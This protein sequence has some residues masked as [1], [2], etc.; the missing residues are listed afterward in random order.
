M[1]DKLSNTLAAL[2]DPTRRAILVRLALGDASVSD[3]AAP[4]DM[5]VRAVSKHIGVLEKAGL[6]SR[7]REAQRRPSRLQLA[8]LQQLSV[9]LD[10]YRRLWEGRFDRIE[11]VI[12]Q[13]K[14]GELNVPRT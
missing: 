6:V 1:T 8:P 9:W 3:L 2:A 13:I 14:K 12:E 11:D 7:G 10:A 4:F 5:S